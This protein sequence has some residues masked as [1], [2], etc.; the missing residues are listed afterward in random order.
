MA[1][2]TAVADGTITTVAGTGVSGYDQDGIP[3]TEAALNG[4][5]V[6]T[7]GAGTLCI[8]DT[9][10]HRIRQV[11][12]DGIIRTIAGTGTSGFSGDGGQ[13]GAAQIAQPVSVAVGGDGS[14]YFA[15]WGS[16]RVRRVA[17]D[18][19]ITTFAGG[20]KETGDGGRA[21]DAD[22][23][24]VFAIALDGAGNL[25][26][27]ERFGH[28][29]R[30]VDADGVIRT[31]AGT[32]RAGYDKDGVPAT[33]ATLDGPKGLAVDGAGNLYIADTGNHRVRMVAPNGT[34]TTVAGTGDPGYIADGGPAAKTRLNAPEGLAVDGDGNL[35]IAD[36]ANH[37]VR[38][39]D[40]D[41]VITTLAGTG[42]G[43][44]HADGG[45]ADAAHLYF[46][47][48]VALDGV[49]NLYIGDGGNNRVR[50]V[51][52]ATRFDPARFPIADLYGAALAP[53]TVQRGQEFDLG[54][55]I[56]NRGP[57][58]VGGENITVVLTLAD[59]L[60]GGPGTSGRRLTR[61]F[62]GV[63]IIPYAQA[64]PNG[65]DHLDALFRVSA[66]ETTP[67]GTYE[68]T[69]EIQYSGELSLKDNTFT[70]P[71]TVVVPQ[72]VS[73]E[74]ALEIR[75]ETVPETPPGQ[76]TKF[77]VRFNSPTG[78]PVNPGDIT[79]RF[80]AP[81][82]FVFTG[83]PSFGYYATI[84]G[85]ITGNLDYRIEGAGRILII[86]AN[87][88]VN[89]TTSDTGPLVYTIGVKA[90][91]GARPGVSADGSA[92]VGKHVP[93]QIAAKV[94]GSA[95]DETALRL[96]QESVP[97]AAPGA[98]ATFNVEIRSLN[99]VPVNPGTVVQTFT[100]PTG[101]AFTGGASYGYY[102]VKPAVTGNLTTRLEDNGRTLVIESNPHV[103]TG[104]TD[105]TALLY[106]LSVRALSDARAGTYDDGKAVIGRLAPVPLAGHI[107]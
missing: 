41:G 12:T 61:T 89:T 2:P 3:A 79:Q 11:T 100:A 24:N 20:G 16:S 99:N 102:Y 45:P 86:T 101:F 92:S 76:Q 74:T 48:T 40:R 107:L 28:R 94:T 75:Q 88:H 23:R 54:A 82:G 84:H 58:T 42:T 35:Y 51:A 21:V 8:A 10:N 85:V 47:N 1:T 67:A 63:K 4:S 32:G 46:P 26:L 19:V 97:Q 69:L 38:R 80:T 27:T 65:W 60:A 103:N 57:N 5:R 9:N 90:L 104:S 83:Q 15:T 31:V 91:P 52:G 96:T 98:T 14:V 50:K 73:D 7:D 33:T 6:A 43:G 30:K 71:V 34:I 66:P 29:V 105:P 70:L 18:G 64:L 17:P 39:V 36:S 87:P 95:Q 77:N 13:A 53:H 22:L 25:Y 62:P 44:Y 55:R 56:R 68:C 106:T 49:G 93:I 59:G 37:R 72:D 81:T 78:Q